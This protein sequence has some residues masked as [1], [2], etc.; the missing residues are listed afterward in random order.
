MIRLFDVMDPE[1]GEPLTQNG[2]QVIMNCPPTREEAIR[3]GFPRYYVFG[4][5]P[6]NPRHGGGPKQPMTVFARSN[7]RGCCVNDHAAMEYHYALQRGEPLSS[8][9]ASARGLDYFWVETAFQQ[10]GHPGKATLKGKCYECHSSRVNSPR[11]QA[12]RNG[13]VWYQPDVTDPCSNGHVAPR[14]VSNGSCKECEEMRKL[15]P[16]ELPI[17]K[18]FPADQYPD[19]IISYEDAK[20]CGLV[21]YRTGKPCRYGHNDWRYVS[22]MGCVKCAG[23]H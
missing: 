5:C 23:R 16:E 3:D 20:T 17:Y 14:R 18:Q 8:S 9:E 10:C 19:M 1:T 2:R 22:T 7:I 6:N 12:I 4:V 21:A 11:Q 15:E 13:Q